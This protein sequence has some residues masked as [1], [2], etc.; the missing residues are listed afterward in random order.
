MNQGPTIMQKTVAG[1]IQFEATNGVT[2]AT[3]CVTAATSGVTAAAVMSISMSKNLTLSIA[4]ATNQLV[5]FA[6]GRVKF[7]L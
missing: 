5:A 2:A 1:S 6:I 4:N 3:S 7:F